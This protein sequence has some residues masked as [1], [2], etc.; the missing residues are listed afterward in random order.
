MLLSQKVQEIAAETCKNCCL[1]GMAC[2]CKQPFALSHGVT[3][4]G[5][6]MQASDQHSPTGNVGNIYVADSA[7]GEGN[8]AFRPVR[9]HVRGSN[10]GLAGIGH[11]A[12][13]VPAS[14]WTPTRFVF[15]R[16]PFG[17]GNRNGQ[18]S[19]ANDDAELRPD[20]NADMSGDGLTALV[21][22]SDGGRNIINGHGGQA[23]R[24]YEMDLRDTF[25]GTSD[26]GPSG[27]GIQMAESS[28][29]D[30]DVLMRWENTDNASISL[31]MKTPL[32]HFPPFRFGL[33]FFPVLF[34]SHC[35]SYL[36]TRY[37]VCH[38]S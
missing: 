38:S 12:T 2:A 1:L 18:Q 10:E 13:F 20:Q 37:L 28:D 9:V 22:L 23:E 31:D 32:S 6:Y 3:T 8:G 34:D 16:V 11:G 25:V 29:Q 7:Q 14:A 17:V 19:L 26:A 33:V 24:V 36:G 27:G 35:M 21:G 30:Q 4:T 15:S 5:Y